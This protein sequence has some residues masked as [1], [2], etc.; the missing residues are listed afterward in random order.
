MPFD[1]RAGFVRLAE[2][3]DGVG[4]DVGVAAEFSFVAGLLELA[5]GLDFGADFGAAGSA[6]FFGVEF[7]EGEGRHVDVEIDAVEEGSGEAV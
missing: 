2:F 7:V 5:G 6:G 3:S 1:A 4:V